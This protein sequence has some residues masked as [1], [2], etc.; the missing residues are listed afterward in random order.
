MKRIARILGIGLLLLSA[1]SVSGKAESPLAEIRTQPDALSAGQAHVQGIC[2]D[3]EAIYLVFKNVIFKIDWSG[4]VIKSAEVQT[5]SGDPC[6][7][8]G[9]LFVSMSAPDGIGLY[10][11]NTDLELLAKHPLEKARG[12]DGITF[13]DGYF[14]IGG[15]SVGEKS[16]FDNVIHKYDRDFN[17]VSEMTVNYGE[18]T[19]YGT[20]AIEAWNGSLIMAFYNPEEVQIR[21]IRTDQ[22]MNVL[23]RYPMFTANGIA[24]VPPSK[25]GEK[26]RFIVASTEYTPDKKPVAVLRWYEFD[27]NDFTDITE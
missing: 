27:G 22:E 16:H 5:H 11:Y 12:T 20:Q 25:Q 13:I 2:C 14:F 10:E 3:E 21:T 26:T 15:P 23:G 19:H 17:L 24:Q 6:L 4:N 18:P 8:D 1:F 7:A 9:H